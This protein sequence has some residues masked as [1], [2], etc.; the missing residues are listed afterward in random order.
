[1]ADEVKNIFDSINRAQDELVTVIND[2]QTAQDEPLPVVGDIIKPETIKALK[3][4][5]GLVKRPSFWFSVISFFG[6]FLGK[7]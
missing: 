7:K 4:V 1:M 3:D 6:R 2:A 5:K